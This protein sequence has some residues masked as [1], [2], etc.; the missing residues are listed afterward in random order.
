MGILEK[1]SIE[2][3]FITRVTF[4]KR[5]NQFIAEVDVDGHKKMVHGKMTGEK[6]YG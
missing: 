2:Q 6:G 4:V 1:I 3:A 5:K